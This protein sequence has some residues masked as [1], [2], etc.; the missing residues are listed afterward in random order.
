[1]DWFEI[2]GLPQWDIEGLPQWDGAS[3]AATPLDGSEWGARYVP[4]PPMPTTDLYLPEFG[5]TLRCKRTVFQR[6]GKVVAFDAESITRT[7]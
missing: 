1:M 7:T 6:D 3:I 4:V 5:L 2:E